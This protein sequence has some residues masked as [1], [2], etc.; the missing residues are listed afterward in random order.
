MS[1]KIL[2]YGS[3]NID[4][5]F[6]VPHICLT[7]ETLS[8][9]EYFVR[10][11]GKGIK[12]KKRYDTLLRDLYNLGANQSIAFAKAG[13]CVYHA[14]NFGHDAVWIKDFMNENGVDMTF[15]NIKKNEVSFEHY[16]FIK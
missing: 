12:A 13:G 15:A 3:V 7:G 4:E 6:S 5:F 11:G 10:A 9:T 16:P 8:S 2:N 14:G 1:K